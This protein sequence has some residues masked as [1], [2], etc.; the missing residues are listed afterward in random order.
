MNSALH[1]REVAS[2]PGTTAR[3]T[4]PEESSLPEALTSDD[5]PALSAV[6][7]GTA[8][9]T[10]GEFIQNL[11][12][13]LAA[14]IDAH[15]IELATGRVMWSEPGL[16]RTALPLVDGHLVCLAEDGVLQLLKVNPHKFDEMSQLTV[17]GLQ[18][19]C[20]AAPI[21]AH[22]LLYVRG[23]NRLICLE[24]MPSKP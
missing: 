10:G 23:R 7:E 1:S 11:V 4:G 24:L 19:P 15:S 2:L 22:G 9:S 21:L 8:Q 5:I 12:C 13:H 14:A 20:W 18:Q 17:P 3:P 6:V 16:K